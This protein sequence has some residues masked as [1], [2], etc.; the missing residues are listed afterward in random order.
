MFKPLHAALTALGVL[1]LSACSTQTA[2]Q[3]ALPEETVTVTG[4]EK[5][6]PDTIGSQIV[7]GTV[8][9][10]TNRPYQVSVTPSTELSGGWC[11]GTLI[12]STWVM[13]AAHCVVGYSAS[14]M[15]VRAGINDLTTTSGQLRTP[16]QIIVHP[17]YS[18]SG[19][20]YDIALI[21]VGTAFTLGSTV[22]TAALPS[23]T[24][25]SVLDVNG[26]YATVSGWGKTETG[27]YSNRA[28]REVTIPITPTGSDCGSRP[29]NTICGKYDAGKDSC[30]GDSGGPLAARYNNRF[31]VLGIVSYGPTACRGYGVYTRVNGYL[32]WI[33]S[34][35]GVSA[36]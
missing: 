7:Y 12:S 17:Y 33:S 32:N 13:T 8:T 35:T 19:D 36:Q 20:A 30:N 21:K 10:V 5:A 3:A 26:K 11:G 27:A 4:T 2:P 9:N 1:A 23:N 16:S 24:V 15:R 22:Q 28:L 14:Q 6:F 31:Y 29:S 25:E 18:S 34:N